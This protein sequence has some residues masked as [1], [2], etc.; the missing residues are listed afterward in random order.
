M[1]EINR[2]NLDPDVA[3]MI[4]GPKREELA[5]HPYGDDEEWYAVRKIYL[6]MADKFGWVRIDADA[7]I[8]TVANRIWAVVKPVLAGK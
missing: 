7:P 6:Q 8:L 5:G 4:D 3:V 2:D 1:E